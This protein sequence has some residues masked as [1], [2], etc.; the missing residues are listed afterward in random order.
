M[1]PVQTP[2]PSS[3]AQLVFD[4]L[5]RH[6]AMFFDELRTDVRLLDTELETAL[7]ELVSLGL[8]NADSF[9]GL[10]ALLAPA[11]RRNSFGR[12]RRGGRFIGGMD[13]AGRWAVAA[14]RQNPPLR[15][16]SRSNTSP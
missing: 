13:D 12:R 5:T 8:V 11:A 16:D 3:R 14:P 7:G 1:Q 9:A 6:G 4:A 2:E 15:G 10:R